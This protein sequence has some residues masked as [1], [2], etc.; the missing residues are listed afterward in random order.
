[1]KKHPFIIA[2]TL[3]TLA[4]A[5]DSPILNSLDNLDK[6]QKALQPYVERGRLQDLL[7]TPTEIEDQM[8]AVQKIECKDRKPPCKPSD[9]MPES[10]R[11]EM[12]AIFDKMHKEAPLSYRGLSDC[13]KGIDSRNVKGHERCVDD[14][15][16]NIERE[17]FANSK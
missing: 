10:K 6:S 9:M 14:L 17:K 2:L 16:K 4:H 13:L 5:G 7:M 8:Y 11:S 15:K 1:M 3:G 12:I